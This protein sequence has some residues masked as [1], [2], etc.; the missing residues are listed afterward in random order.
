M[1]QPLVMKLEDIDSKEDARELIGLDILLPESAVEG[2]LTIEDFRLL[3]G[4]TVLVEEVGEIGPILAIESY[5]EQ[6][7]ALVQYGEKEVLI[8]LNETFLQ[9]IYPEEQRVEMQ[10]PEGLLDL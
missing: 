9:A 3:E 2:Q 1:D 10:L 8:P 7:M 4:F 5:P 6:I